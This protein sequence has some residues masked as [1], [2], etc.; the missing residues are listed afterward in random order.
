MNEFQK[1]LEQLINKHS[2]ESVADIPDFI[3]SEM[4][5]SMINAMGPSIKQVL[6]WHGC[7][8]VCH[9]PADSVPRA[10][11]QKIADAASAGMEVATDAEVVEAYK[12]MLHEI[13]VNTGVT[14][15]DTR[16]IRP[17]EFKRG[18]ILPRKFEDE[19]A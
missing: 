14:P 9:H 2:I 8:S 7:S 18:T 15:S 3:F 11:V 1:E 17:V 4:I 13:R 10:L 19:E 12:N 5:C 16:D 6:D